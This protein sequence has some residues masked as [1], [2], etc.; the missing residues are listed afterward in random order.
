[1]RRKLTDRTLKSLKP[2]PL[3]KTFDIFDDIVRGLA[4]RVSETGRRTFILVARYPG[5]PHPTRRSLG[6][7]GAVTLDQARQKARQWLDLIK[8]GKDPAREAERERAAEARK[9]ATTFASVAEDFIAE[10][11]PGERKGREVERDIRNQFMPAWSTRPITEITDLDL[12]QIIRAKKATAPAQAR[13]LLGTAKRLFAWAADQRVYGLSASPFETLR[14]VKIVGDKVVRVRT[15]DD[16]ELFA[17]WRA[18]SRMRYPFGDVYRL[19]LLTGLR[20]N[21]AADA[22][23]S[24]VN[25]RE[26]VW[27]IP[28]ARMKGKEGKARPHAVPL[29]RDIGDLLDKLPRFNRGKYLFS[30]TFGEAPAWM[31]NKVKA[32]LDARMLSTLRALAKRRGDDPADV[33]LPAWKN[34][35]IRRTVRTRLSRLKISEEAREAVLAHAR[36]GIK[37][38]YDHHEYLAEKIEALELWAD[39]LR[40]IVEPP[41]AAPQSADVIALASRRL[42]TGL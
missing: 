28:E 29:T 23:W 9:Q 2:A 7:Y 22:H 36:P 1:M 3:G 10:K 11:L 35:D 31:S 39:A 42:L 26:G 13:N 25:R 41:P 19:L 18:A 6:E 5:S 32:R 30:T 21:E 14:P 34:H 4:V 33:T 12:L 20:L 17:L 38:T 24:E 15:L 16:D 27:I 37:A 8:Q 40:R